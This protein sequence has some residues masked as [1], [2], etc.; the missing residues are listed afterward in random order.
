VPRLASAE[1]ESL[2]G[3]RARLAGRRVQRSL[4]ALEPGSKPRRR[5]GRACG[6]GI[7]LHSAIFTAL[8]DDSP[9]VAT[10]DFCAVA[11]LVALG[12]AVCLDGPGRSAVAA[13]SGALCAELCTVAM[14]TGSIGPAVIIFVVSLVASG[15]YSCFESVMHS[16]HSPLRRL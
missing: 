14:A 2:Q 6:G 10:G 4:Q 1:A 5:E 7:V 8:R 11:P 16:R 3:K 15:P 9:S 12:A 13:P